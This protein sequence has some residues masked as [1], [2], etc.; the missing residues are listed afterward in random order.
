MKFEPREFIKIKEVE[1]NDFHY[2]MINTY[3]VDN[4]GNFVMTCLKKLICNNYESC[5][6]NEIIKLK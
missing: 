6:C 2:P 3:K 5:N 4:N 1:C